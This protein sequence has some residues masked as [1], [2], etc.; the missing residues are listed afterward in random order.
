MN[1][2]KILKPAIRY[3]PQMP[4]CEHDVSAVTLQHYQGIKSMNADYNV[5]N[6]CKKKSSIRING[7]NYCLSH[8]GMVAID[9]LLEENK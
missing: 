4:R 6:R 8:A 7:K 2:I 3:I 1:K 5:E 9:I